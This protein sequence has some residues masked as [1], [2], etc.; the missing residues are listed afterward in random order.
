MNITSLSSYY[1]SGLV[2]I[3]EAITFQQQLCVH[4]QFSYITGDLPACMD[5]GVYR[6]IC[7]MCSD[8]LARHEHGNIC[9]DCSGNLPW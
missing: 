8:R 9:G 2:S 4:R 7:V 5:C 3:D 1:N 6:Q